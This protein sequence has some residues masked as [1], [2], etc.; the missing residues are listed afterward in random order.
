[1]EKRVCQR[2]RKSWSGCPLRHCSWSCHG[3]PPRVTK[4]RSS[5]WFVGA[6]SWGVLALFFIERE[7]KTH[8]DVDNSSNPA[9][10]VSVKGVA[11]QNS[12]LRN[13]QKI[14]RIR[15]PCKRSSARLTSL[16]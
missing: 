4:Y 11:V 13:T 3:A 14:D 12:L 1:M 5:S 10:R 9:R 15:M 6:P 16:D 7:M 8:Y 2:P